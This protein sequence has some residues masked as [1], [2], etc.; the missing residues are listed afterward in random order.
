MVA[1]REYRDWL[2]TDLELVRVCD[3]LIRLPGESPG[4]DLEVDEAERCGVPVYQ[5]VEE[6][7]ARR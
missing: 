6:W 1:P 5:G 2:G 4:A 3:A 7:E